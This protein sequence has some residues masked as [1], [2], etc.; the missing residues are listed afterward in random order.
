MTTSC[1][2]VAEGALLLASILACSQ[3]TAAAPS[4]ALASVPSPA[5]ATFA[6][7]PEVER[8][9]E[10]ALV[11]ARLVCAEVYE[12]TELDAEV[13]PVRTSWDTSGLHYACYPAEVADWNGQL[14]VH[15][16][17]TRDDP[18]RTHGFAEAAC[19]L[20]FAAVAPMYHNELGTRARC[21]SDSACY[22]RVRREILY[23][24]PAGAA[25]LR[26][27]AQNSALHRLDSLLRKLAV[28]EPRFPPWAT[29]RDRITARD[30][31]EVTLSGHSQGS[32]H[33]LMLSRD[34]EAARVVLLAGPPDRLG[35]GQQRHAAVAWIA[36]WAARSKTP[37]ERLWSYLHQDDSV[38]FAPEVSA[39][40][41]ALTVSATTC[42]VTADAAPPLGCRRVH[43]A[44][45]GCRGF[46]AHLTPTLARF[47]VERDLCRITGTRFDN[48]QVW[49]HLLTSPL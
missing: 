38:A 26:I 1:R 45:S 39:T 33:A 18:A 10:C 7:A 36:E 14:L 40:L 49:A 4:A 30:F 12:P 32:G 25:P 47:G 42:E 20:G 2:C 24:Q 19:A 37:A 43:G 9:A 21:G 28:T 8:G 29:L 13:D 46:D 16:V 34:H 15:F 44:A 31:S 23:G 6:A 22:E 48:R 3:P 41:D 11:G 17:G 35:S 27:N 5:T